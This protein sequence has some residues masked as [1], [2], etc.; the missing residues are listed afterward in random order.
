[1][2]IIDTIREL[3]ELE[4]KATPGPWEP[5]DSAAYVFAPESM[6][7]CQIRGWGH[8][9]GKGHGALCLSDEEAIAIQKANQ[10]LIARAR[11]VLPALLDNIEALEARLAKAE[12][13]RDAAVKD[14][15]HMGGCP[16]CKK[17]L[18][19]SERTGV[20]KCLEYREYPS[21]GCFEWRGVPERTEVKHEQG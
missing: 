17:N 16:N 18:G 14:I 5:D 2:N 8:L 1:M 10:Q 11:N 7:I 15:Y 19:R 21:G 4:G 9:T 12:R 6:M 13:E 3:R 20:P